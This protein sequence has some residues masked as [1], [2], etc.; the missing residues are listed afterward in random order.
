MAKKKKTP[1]RRRTRRATKALG[2][3]RQEI[4][5]HL[6][7]KHVRLIDLQSHLTMRGG[8]VPNR[9]KIDCSATVGPSS[10]GHV[11]VNAVLDVEGRPAE[12]GESVV[13]IKIHY[14]CVYSVIDAK[15]EQF[16]EHASEIA[17]VGMLVLWPYFRELVQSLTSRMAIRAFTLPILAPGGRRYIATLEDSPKE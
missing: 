8:K 12:G 9:A 4:F 7:L 6:K 11:H 14:Q 13:N 5:E 15:L 1:S 2:L 3:S 10:D 17:T 16:A